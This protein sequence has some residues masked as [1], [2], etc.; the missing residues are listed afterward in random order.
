MPKP[1]PTWKKLLPEPLMVAEPPD[2]TK[3][4]AQLSRRREGLP[5]NGT[6]P[7]IFTVAPGASVRVPMRVSPLVVTALLSF[8]FVVALTL[9]NTLDVYSLAVSKRTPFP[10]TTLKLLVFEPVPPALFDIVIVVAVTPVMTVPDGMLVPPIG[11]PTARL[12]VLYPAVS[13][14]VLFPLTAVPLNTT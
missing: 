7:A 1:E 6:L 10:V 14:I 11:M 4:P 2:W 13:V 5:A 12:L 3:T 9:S 8:T